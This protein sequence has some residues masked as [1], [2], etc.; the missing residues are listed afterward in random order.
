MQIKIPAT[1]AGIAG[2]RGGHRGRRLDQRDRVLHR[3]PVARRRRGGRA[4]AGRREAAGEDTSRMS[5]VCTIMVGRLDD[6]MARSSSATECRRSGRRST[7]PASPRSS[8]RTAI[9]QRARLPCR[10]L[11]AAYPTSPALVR[12]DRRRHRPH[13]PARVAEAV[14]RLRRSR[15]PSE[16]TTRCP[17]GIVDQLY[18]RLPDFR[19]AYDADGMTVP[20]VRPLRSDRPHAARL[21]RLLPGSRRPSSATSC[22]PTP[23]SSG[24][25]PLPPPAFPGAS[26]IMS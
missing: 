25:P 22:S 15:S 18:A 3:S 26:A 14:Q 2:D 5:P 21:H 12:A 4:R 6:W 10:L 7:G 24:R 11:A 13:D 1:A 8:M 16:W 17:D 19:R 23:T 20:G 9:Y